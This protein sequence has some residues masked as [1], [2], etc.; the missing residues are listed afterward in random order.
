MGEAEM[1]RIAT[2]MHRV[3]QAPDDAQALNRIKAEVEEMAAGF[4]V[5]GIAA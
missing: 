3:A 1:A 5:P 2:W 4:P